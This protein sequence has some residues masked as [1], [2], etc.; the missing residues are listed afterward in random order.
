MRK[1][2]LLFW[3]LINLVKGIFKKPTKISET[4]TD[5]VIKKTFNF[6]GSARRP[7]FNMKLYEMNMEGTISEVVIVENGDEASRG[8]I[9]HENNYVTWALNRKNAIKKFGK[10]LNEKSSVQ[11]IPGNHEQSFVQ[12]SPDP[13]RQNNLK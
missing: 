12:L 5:R 4:T 11:E 2:K 7:Y 1:L 13:V 10:I 8:F 9:T 6:V 3:A